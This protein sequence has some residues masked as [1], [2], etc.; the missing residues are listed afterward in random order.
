MF[1]PLLSPYT[2]HWPH[3]LLGLWVAYFLHKAHNAYMSA[4]YLCVD[5]VELLACSKLSCYLH[6][7]HH[8]PHRLKHHHFCPFFP[9]TWLV[10]LKGKTLFKHSI[11][12]CQISSDVSGFYRDMITRSCVCN[13][14]TCG[15]KQPRQPT[16]SRVLH[17]LKCFE[18][19]SSPSVL[20]PWC[21]I[22][23]LLTVAPAQVR[24]AFKSQLFLQIHL[25]CY[26]R[27]PLTEQF[28]NNRY[29][30][31]TAMDAGIQQS[32][33]QH[34]QVLVSTHFL[35]HKQPSSHCVLT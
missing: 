6:L 20:L 10:G 25:A 15:Y 4:L 14:L 32:N 9:S 3:L 30:F 29:L 2:F 34:S 19:I 1:P 23:S 28:I 7:F 22:L 13:Q 12:K 33:C 5:Y 27:M 8:S 11:W 17:C 35:I 26:K 24:Q 16:S 21:V 18:F 31:R